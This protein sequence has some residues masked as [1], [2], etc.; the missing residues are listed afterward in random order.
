MLVPAVGDDY[1]ACVDPLGGQA[2]IGQEGRHQPT[3]GQFPV[4]GNRIGRGRRA[5]AEERHGTDERLGILPLRVEAVQQGAALAGGADG[6]RERR[7]AVAQRPERLER[8]GQITGSRAAGQR[9]QRVG[10][11]AERGDD[12]HAR[13]P[14]G[15]DDGTD[16]RE[17]RRRRDRGSAEL[18]HDHDAAP[19]A[20]QPRAASSSAFR[21]AAPAAPRIVLWPRATS[22]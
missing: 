10:D 7:V 15:F 4:R 1:A 20:S 17:G 5:G 11:T 16:T 19:P 14:L 12:D 8:V 2:G 6:C 22:L 18:H 9:E 21:I 13:A 3:A